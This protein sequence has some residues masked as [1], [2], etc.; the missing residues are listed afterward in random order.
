MAH[1]PDGTGFLI[2]FEDGVMATK[3]GIRALTGHGN[4]EV[5]QEL[6]GWPLPDR[7]G[8]LAHTEASSVAMWD[9]DDVAAAKLPEEITGSPNALI[10]L[11]VSESQRDHDVPGV[12]RGAA[13]RLET[14]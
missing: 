4:F 6:F 10:Y 12:V 8:V 2:R 9:A 13:Y 14:A 1:A 11:K 5:A 7:L 3:D